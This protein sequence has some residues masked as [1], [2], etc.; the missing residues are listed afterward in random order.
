MIK[1]LFLFLAL[2]TPVSS[3]YAT[4]VGNPA[5][6]GLSGTGIFSSSYS[7][8]KVTTGYVADYTSNKRFET[9]QTVALFDPNQ[10][11]KQFGLHSQMA[12]LSFIFLER[13]EL[14]GSAGGTKEHAVWEPDATLSDA[15]QI[16]SDFQSSYHFSWS[17]GAKAVIFRLGPLLLGG[18]FTYFSVPSSQKSYFQFLNRLNLAMDPKQEF[19]LNEWQLSCALAAHLFFLTPYA[20]ATYLHS[21]L[22]VQGGPNVPALT[23]RNQDSIGY[24]YGVTV[25]LTGRLHL[26]FERRVRDEFAYTFST[27]AV[28]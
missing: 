10:A 5:F 23:Y 3:T 25:S 8:F 12:T 24:F 16:W 11:M 20:G 9:N 28:F 19:D 1:W 15:V 2:G 7:F 27:T 17:V 14:F 6:P 4:Y 21:R 13:L 26:N 22:D 18:D